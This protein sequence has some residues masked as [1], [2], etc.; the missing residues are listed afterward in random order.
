LTPPEFLHLDKTAIEEAAD[1]GYWT[2]FE[3]E[4]FHKDGHRVPIIIGGSIFKEDPDEYIVFI[5]DISDR[6]QAE[7]SLRQVQKLESIGTLAGGVAHEINNPIYIIMNYAE[8]ISDRLSEQD[9][10]RK[11][12]EEIIRETERV[13]TIVSNLLQFSRQE[14]ESHSP[15]NLTDIVEATVSLIQTIIRRDRIALEVDVPEDLPKIKCRSQQIQQV[16]MNLLTNARDALNERYPAYDEDKRMALTVRPFENEGRP[17]I[18]VTVEDHGIGIPD[19]IRDRLFDPFFTTK[20]RAKGTGLGLSI[21]YG[22]VQDHHGALHVESE[23]GQYT[24]FHL[25][26]PVDN[27]WSLDGVQEH[28]SREGG[29]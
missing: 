1:K 3:K 23:V 6:K 20:D 26:L 16:L 17:W 10:S 19:A 5:I 24:R 2:P 9:P 25:E 21:S 29:A 13:A 7:A 4:Y 22:I 15:A 8:L 27:G 18:R 12:A 14:K 28:Q 11:Y